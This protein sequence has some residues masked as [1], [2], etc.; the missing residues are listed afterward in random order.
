MS[1]KRRQRSGI[2]EKIEAGQARPRQAMKMAA[3]AWPAPV[4]PPNQMRTMEKMA[5]AMAMR[6]RRSTRPIRLSAAGVT[7][8]AKRCRQH[9]Q[10]QEL[11][12]E[13]CDAARPGGFARL[14]NG[15]TR[16]RIARHGKAQ[17][18]ALTSMKPCR[19]TDRSCLSL[20]YSELARLRDSGPAD[21]WPRQRFTTWT[22]VCRLIVRAWQV[23]DANA[24]PQ[25]GQFGG[26][27]YG[28]K[29]RGSAV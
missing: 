3:T 18:A 9:R 22:L 23:C 17:F 26:A 24:R 8:E 19:R 27:E 14:L 10:D 1:V 7:S 21:C 13:Q 5:M 11:H 6:V 25:I 2:G 16:G 20:L 4:W 12:E 28:R 29:L 15:V